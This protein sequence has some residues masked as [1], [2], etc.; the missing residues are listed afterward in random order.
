MFS[1]WLENLRRE[2]GEN[3]EK[4]KAKVICSRCG[5]D[6]GEEKWAR[7]GETLRNIYPECFRKHF[8][9]V[10]DEEIE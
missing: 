3:K 2:E 9:G 1:E 4:F 10:K 6:M 7:E 5:K 8:L